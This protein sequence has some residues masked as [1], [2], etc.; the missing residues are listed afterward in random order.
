MSLTVIDV[1]GTVSGSPLPQ[2]IVS[3]TSGVSRAKFRV[4]INQSVSFP[5]MYLALRLQ[6]HNSVVISHFLQSVKLR[7]SAEV[8]DRDIDSY[9]IQTTKYVW[10]ETRTTIPLV[11]ILKF[12]FRPSKLPARS[13]FG[14]KQTT[15][16]FSIKKWC[17][18]CYSRK[19]SNLIPSFKL[20]L[21][22]LVS[23]I[24]LK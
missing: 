17:K 6:Q 7:R 16:L 4:R 12:G 9:K 8:H 23:R 3:Q 14:I 15:F 2:S 21:Y 22:Y 5:V 19:I 11:K 1:S 13:Y 20:C 10:A 24:I 18:M